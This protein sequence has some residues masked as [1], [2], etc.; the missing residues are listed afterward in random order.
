MFHG[1]HSAG[2]IPII[3]PGE[4]VKIKT[5]ASGFGPIEVIVK[6]DDAVKTVS[7]FI[8]GPFVKI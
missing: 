5:K 4:N 3:T 7:G 2:S 6:V 1:N 8:F